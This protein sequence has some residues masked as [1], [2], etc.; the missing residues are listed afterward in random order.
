MKSRFRVF[1]GWVIAFVLLMGLNAG[2]NLHSAWAETATLTDEQRNAIDMLNYITVLTQSINA[3]KN[4]R[5]Y[6][7]DAYTSLVNNTNPNSV[8]SRTLSQLTGLLDTMENYR[9]T[10]VKRDRLQYIYE[11]NQAQAIRSAAPNPLNV[12]SLV[13]AG[14]LAKTAAAIVFTAIDA[15]NS[16]AAQKA[17]VDLEF[18]KEG[19]VLDDA[20][21][22]TLHDSRKGTFAYMINMV[23]DYGL[24][25]NLVLTENAVEEFVSWKNNDNVVGRI[26]F[27]ESNKS[28]Y[29]AYSGYWL[30]LAKSYYEDREYQKCLD[31]VHA[32]ESMNTH[33]FRK[34]YALAKIL[35][36]VIESAEIALK[37]E[38]AVPAM[39][40]YA[41]TLLDNTDHDAWALRYF[42]AQAYISLYSKT[43]EQVYLQSAYDV[44]LDNVNYLVNKQKN[45]NA[46]Y[47]A[48]VQEMTVPKDA[49]KSQKEQIT[50]HNKMI[51]KQ[52][53]TEL[54]PVYEPL[55][56]NCDLMFA[57]AEQLHI[58]E[59][60]QQ[61]IDG[62][63]RAKGE[64]IFLCE[65]LD[66][67]YW[68]RKDAGA[69][70]EKEAG[71]DYAGTA[72]RLP[73]WQVTG[74]TAIKVSIQG[75]D[76]EPLILTDWVVEKV[77]RGTEG[78]ISSYFAIYASVEAKKH[79]WQPDESIQIDVTPKYGDELASYHF[80][81]RTEGTKKTWVDYLKVWE[82]QKNNWYDYAKVWENSVKFERVK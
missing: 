60:E 71:V 75:K 52:R 43:N 25:G 27:L 61:K 8:D 77:E 72:L 9:M 45:M 3:S 39:A 34:D 4:S 46:Q 30:L 11:Q 78:D 48:A 31:A 63:L 14:S 19:W 54:A 7:E 38:D 15:Y 32:Y 36:I 13:Q 55:A 49:T 28:T 51:K 5:L 23:H 81:Y 79:A 73:V 67:Q 74:D 21:A 37:S 33:I 20:E 80:E 57:L 66:R 2:T 64:P 65:P 40:G 35:P 24:P 16:Y 26:H 53:E 1:L 17:E 62:I 42:V 47:L 44:V 18:V 59:S 29:D 68:F 56:L 12:L 76:A 58:S 10:S 70:A 82:G 22:A 50:N 6:L 41:Q 69:D